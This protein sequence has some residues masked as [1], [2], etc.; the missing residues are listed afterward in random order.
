MKKD[1]ERRRME[2]AER[3]KIM[4]SADVDENFSPLS[5]RASTH[6]VRSAS[7]TTPHCL[8]LAGR[9]IAHDV[10]IPVDAAALY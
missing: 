4:S 9:P 6:K 2:A 10:L 5:P 7:S 1:M 8:L 3:V